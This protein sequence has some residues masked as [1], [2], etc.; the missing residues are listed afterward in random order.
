MKKPSLPSLIV[1]AISYIER[2][3]M[4][5]SRIQPSMFILRPTKKSEMTMAVKAM[6]VEAELETKVANNRIEAGAVAIAAI[7][8]TNIPSEL[9]CL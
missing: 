6:S 2:G 1:S 3:P 9:K 7:L 8:K 4:S 5:L